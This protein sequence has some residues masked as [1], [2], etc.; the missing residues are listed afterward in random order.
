MSLATQ[1]EKQT[2]REDIIKI[3][4]KVFNI[5]SSEFRVDDVPRFIWQ[6]GEEIK[7]TFNDLDDFSIIRLGKSFMFIGYQTKCEKTRFLLWIY[8]F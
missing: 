1:E 7:K 8:L 3:P 5:M 4:E 6:E 2:P